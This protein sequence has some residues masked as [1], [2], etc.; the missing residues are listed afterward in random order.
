MTV[1]GARVTI[2]TAT[3]E[4]STLALADLLIGLRER[5]PLTEAQI[6]R[7]TGAEEQTVA[8]WLERRATPSGVQANRVVELTTFVEEMA[9]NITAESLPRWLEGKVDV[10]DGAVP[11]EMIAAGRYEPM[12]DYALGLSQGVFT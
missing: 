1:A 9:R 3:A 11:L 6:A 4:S 12:M 2:V 7:A 10:L 5:V 8:A